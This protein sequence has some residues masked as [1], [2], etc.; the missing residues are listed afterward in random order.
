MVMEPPQSGG[1]DTRSQRD[2][3]VSQSQSTSLLDVTNERE[4]SMMH[5][6]EYLRGLGVESINPL[7]QVIVCGAQSSGKSSLLKT[8]TGIPFHCGTYMCTRYITKVTLAYSERE[9]VTVTILADPSRKDA[10]KLKAF[11]RT[12]FGDFRTSPTNDASQLLLQSYMDEARDIIF[13]DYK[14]NQDIVNDVLSIKISGPKRR[15]M[16]LV[17]LPGLIDY[18]QDRSE[19]SDKIEQMVKKYVRMSQ[20]IILAVVSATNEFSLAR[21]LRWCESA[22]P[23]GNRTIRV[24]ARPDL[25]GSAREAKEQVDNIRGCNPQFSKFR[26]HVIRSRGSD[27]IDAA[28]SIEELETELFEREPWNLVPL[29]DRGVELLNLKISDKYFSAGAQELPAME[30]KINRLLEQ[31]KYVGLDDDLKAEDKAWIF[32]QAVKR[33][34]KS[35]NAHSLRNYD[36]ETTRFSNDD[37]IMLRSRIRH[38]D[39]IFYNEMTLRGHTGL[40]PLDNDTPFIHQLPPTPPSNLSSSKT[41]MNEITELEAEISKLAKELTETPGNEF[42]GH[43]TPAVIDKIFWD[44]SEKW[45]GIALQYVEK[46]FDCCVRYFEAITKLKFARTEDNLLRAGDGKPD[47]FINASMVARRFIDDHIMRKLQEARMRAKLELWELE[48]DRRGQ[49]KDPDARFLQNQEQHRKRNEFMTTVGARRSEILA[50]KMGESDAKYLD[51]EKLAVQRHESRREDFTRK[52]AAEYLNDARKHYCI[53][54]D[55]Y[56]LNVLTQVQERHFLRQIEELIPD[57]LDAVAIEDLLKEDDAAERRKEELR[58]EKANLEAARDALKRW[59]S[60]MEARVGL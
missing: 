18:V 1:S 19:L 25:V 27:P 34:K 42:E 33:L 22:D 58:K 21:I 53:A 57:D 43:Y 2:P 14:S 54:R 38:E 49:Q 29:A 6:I 50:S 52:V 31:D 9:S 8:I 37:P 4:H 7:P 5:T 17:D 51:D 32:K 40:P 24:V 36:Y 23:K 44:M 13:P 10:Q 16:V 56:I 59:R 30:Q 45:R 11:K 28:K 35:A 47:G 60:G 15:A 46:V 55:T 12:L 26:W 39:R 48:K 41:P 3:P 20:S